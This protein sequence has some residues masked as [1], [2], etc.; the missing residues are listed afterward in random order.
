MSSRCRNQ[1][2]RRCIARLYERCRC[3]VR[4]GTPHT[5]TACSG[6]PV[7][8]WT[9]HFNDVQHW[10]QTYVIRPVPSADELRPVQRGMRRAPVIGMCLEFT[11]APDGPTTTMWRI[12][13]HFYLYRGC[14]S[15]E[16]ASS[17]RLRN[18]LLQAAR[19]WLIASHDTERFF[20]AVSFTTEESRKKYQA[21][22]KSSEL[23]C[24]MRYL[25]R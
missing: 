25:A 11:R 2:Y 6:Q 14:G 3:Q 9:G 13:R 19:C 23:R 5:C 20:M 16:T 17:R 15:V 21:R 4:Q 22:S 10:R 7:S 1:R 8:R 18:C 24:Y 12:R